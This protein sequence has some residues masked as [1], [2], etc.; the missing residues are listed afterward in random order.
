MGWLIVIAASCLSIALVDKLIWMKLVD[1]TSAMEDDEAAA[2]AFGDAA[3]SQGGVS[4]IL[5]PI[6]RDAGLLTTGV[7]VS[8]KRRSVDSADTPAAA[9]VPD[10]PPAPTDGLKAELIGL[11]ALSAVAGGFVAAAALG[12]AS[13]AFVALPGTIAVGAF[14]FWLPSLYATS[15]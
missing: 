5:R 15:D 6:L 2:P 12:H 9:D 11:Q 7:I 13:N 4:H 8:R 14:C 3:T 1:E 10:R